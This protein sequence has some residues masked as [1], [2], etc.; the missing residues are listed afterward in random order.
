M[1]SEITIQCPTCRASQTLSGICRRCKCDL[2]LLQEAYFAQR[3]WT[4]DC[5]RALAENRYQEARVLADQLWE[6]DPLNPT[7]VRL[8]AVSSFY[9]GD[10]PTVLRA[11]TAGP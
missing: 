7:T 11:L 1:N 3:R 4:A 5:L 10:F 9:A 6:L 2:T 8:V